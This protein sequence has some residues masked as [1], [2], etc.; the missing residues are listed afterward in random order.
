MYIMSHYCGKSCQMY[1]EFVLIQIG[2]FLLTVNIFGKL[3]FLQQPFFPLQVIRKVGKAL[4]YMISSNLYAFIQRGVSN[5]RTN[6][7]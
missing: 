2:H 4:L 5:F 3:R 6:G 7:L 1:L